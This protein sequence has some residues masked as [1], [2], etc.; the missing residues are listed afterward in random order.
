MG[1]RSSYTNQYLYLFGLKR[2]RFGSKPGY[3]ASAWMSANRQKR[4]QNID[5]RYSPRSRISDTLAL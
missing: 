5:C 3:C 4:T 1:L 2:V